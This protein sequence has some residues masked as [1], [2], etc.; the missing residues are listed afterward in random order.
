MKGAVSDFYIGWCRWPR[1]SNDGWRASTA[2]TLNRDE[3]TKVWRLGSCE[4]FVDKWE[5][6]V[7]DVLSD[8]E[9]VETA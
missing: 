9:P 7:F 8:S 1:K 2:R 6:L 4:N 3:V 5:A